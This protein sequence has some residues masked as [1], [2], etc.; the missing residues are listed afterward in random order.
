MCKIA[1]CVIMAFLTIM[2]IYDVKKR[3]IPFLMLFT[4]SIVTVVFR[5]FCV[6]DG[7]WSTIAGL[8]IGLA[9]FVASRITGEAIGYGDSW[10]I[11]LLGIYMGGM[12][13]LEVILAASL[14]VGIFS[15]VCSIKNGW[16]RKQSFPF[17]PFLAASYLGVVL[18]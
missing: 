11:T 15:I 14:G 6:E 10:I 8:V 3:E 12:N 1:D 13:L 17:V 5:F 4:M 16:N 7:L 18:L 2:G 9:F